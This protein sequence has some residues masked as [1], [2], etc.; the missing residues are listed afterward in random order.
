MKCIGD[1]SF[2]ILSIQSCPIPWPSFSFPSTIFFWKWGMILLFLLFRILNPTSRNPFTNRIFRNS[3]CIHFFRYSYNTLSIP[4]MTSRTRNWWWISKWSE[5]DFL[6]FI[7]SLVYAMILSSPSI[8]E[9]R[10]NTT[11][12]PV[13]ISAELNPILIFRICI[14]DIN[15]SIYCSRILFLLTHWMNVHFVISHFVSYFSFGL[16]AKKAG[17]ILIEYVQIQ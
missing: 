6:L 15:I 10:I 17:L 12:T 5:I 16:L 9:N 7:L 4:F 3:F 13:I 14:H 1:S 2:A 8:Q 11:A